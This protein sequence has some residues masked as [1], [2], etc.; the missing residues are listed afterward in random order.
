MLVILLCFKKPFD[1]V[2]VRLTSFVGGGGAYA[3]MD[4]L[5]KEFSGLVNLNTKKGLSLNSRSLKPDFIF[6]DIA[7]VGKVI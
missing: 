3:G 6:D 2:L 5:V 1:F 4:L 7:G